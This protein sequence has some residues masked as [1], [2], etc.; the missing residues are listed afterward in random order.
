MVRV[1]FE[2][3]DDVHRAILERIARK[4]EETPDAIN[5]I[6][7]LVAAQQRTLLTAGSHPPGTK[8]GSPPGSPPWRITGHFMDSVTV[9]RARPVGAWRWEGKVGATAVYSRIQELGGWTGRG[10]RTHLPARPS[11]RPAWDLVRPTVSRTFRA[12]WG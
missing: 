9:Q 8:T 3:Q 2:G 7:R 11:L 10:H 4:A 6:L 1:H 5:A 12:T